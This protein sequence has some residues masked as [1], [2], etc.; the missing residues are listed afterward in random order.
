MDFQSPRPTLKQRRAQELSDA[1]QR[2]YRNGFEKGEK[3]LLAT[4]QLRRENVERGLLD[5]LGRMISATSQM[6]ESAARIV[7]ELTGQRRFV[8]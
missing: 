8:P 1:E 5:S 7:S 2:G 3:S 6:T 4:E